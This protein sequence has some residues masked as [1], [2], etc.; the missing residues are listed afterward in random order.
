[1][2]RKEKRD[3]KNPAISRTAGGPWAN[4]ILGI[5]GIENKTPSKVQSSNRPVGKGS[6]GSKK[7]KW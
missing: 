1:M 2:E 7:N 4:R 6:G 5:G 3:E